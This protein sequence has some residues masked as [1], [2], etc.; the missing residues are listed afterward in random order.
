MQLDELL[1]KTT[2]QGLRREYEIEVL[3]RL[4]RSRVFV[5]PCYFLSLLYFLYADVYINHFL[6]AA[7]ARV[8]VLVT[9]V[10]FAW[11]CLVP[12]WYYRWGFLLHHVSLFGVMAMMSYILAV[13]VDQPFY[14]S[15]ITAL[16]MIIVIVLVEERG[17][18][19][20][21]LPIYGLCAAALAIYFFQLDLPP[22]KATALGNPAVFVI[23]CLIYSK[24]QEDFRWRDFINMKTIEVQK[25][26]A[27]VLYQEVLAK[28][29]EIAEQKDEMT[30]QNSVLN[31]QMED[32]RQKNHFIQHQHNTIM[33]SLAYAK[34]LQSATLPYAQRFDEVFGPGQYFILFKP[35]DLVSGDFYWL[36]SDAN[37]VLLAVVDCTGHGVPGAFMSLIGSQL[38]TEIVELRQIFSPEKILDELH[39]QTRRILQQDQSESR[40][41][42]EIQLVR[43][44]KGSQMVEFAGAMNPCY[45]L[46]TGA[47][48]LVELKG[49]KKAIGGEQGEGERHFTRHEIPLL[50][51]TM[52]YL[53]TDGYQDQFGGPKKRKFMTGQLRE[54]L[55]RVAGE[56]L[57]TQHQILDSTL[58]SWCR[59]TS[60]PQVDDIT[61]LGVRLG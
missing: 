33:T 2:T 1:K 17:G 61:V 18:L 28:S 38:L 23:T 5:L 19:R 57:I 7:Y 31:Q 56:P 30:A 21:T 52:F 59:E 27:E 22:G 48:E 42:M 12:R 35:R 26:D 16:I 29:R 11:V 25:Q 6:P 55:A 53:C 4:R 14:N 39:K 46:P 20:V 47:T 32:A 60:Q 9:V 58:E 37:Q 50:G 43:W 10:G 8:P 54:L 45:Y 13:S 36:Y 40:D 15:A 41:G 34:L 3:S 49:D 44:Q 51:P 24:L